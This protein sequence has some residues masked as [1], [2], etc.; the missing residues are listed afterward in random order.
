MSSKHNT[1]VPTSV[2]EDIRC[3]TYN[4]SIQVCIQEGRIVRKNGTAVAEA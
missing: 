4:P 2:E 3:N 1:F